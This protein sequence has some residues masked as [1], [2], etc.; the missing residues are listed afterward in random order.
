MNLDQRIIVYH[1]VDYSS[2]AHFVPFGSDF[3]LLSK[4]H[5]FCR[6]IMDDEEDTETKMLQLMWNIVITTD[7][8]FLS[9]GYRVQFQRIIHHENKKEEITDLIVEYANLGNG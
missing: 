9:D 3:W 5:G 2:S 7:P 8:E 6:G 1:R 4:K